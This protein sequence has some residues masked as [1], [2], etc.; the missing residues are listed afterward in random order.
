[1]EA[2]PPAAFLASLPSFAP[3]FP[4]RASSF[5]EPV[6]HSLRLGLATPPAASPRPAS[7]LRSASPLSGAR[8][9]TQGANT[10]DAIDTSLSLQA[11]D[12]GAEGRARSPSEPVA[13]VCRAPHGDWRWW[14]AEFNEGREDREG[15]VCVIKKRNTLPEKIQQVCARASGEWPNMAT[16][17]HAE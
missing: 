2:R 9:S 10:G 14:R 6:R 11:P 1:M 5:P 16:M 3:H 13:A 8:G 15:K 4:M 7:P 17:R 12:N